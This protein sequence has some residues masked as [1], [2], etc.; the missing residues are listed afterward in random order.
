[1][2]RRYDWDEL[3]RWQAQEALG[4]AFLVGMIIG[5]VIEAVL[6]LGLLGLLWVVF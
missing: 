1:M 6:V 5:S 3:P 4:H 2:T